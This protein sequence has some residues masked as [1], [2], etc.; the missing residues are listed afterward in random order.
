MSKCS[1]PVT[2]QLHNIYGSSF[3]KPLWYQL[4]IGWPIPRHPLSLLS[5]LSN[6]QKSVPRKVILN[7]A[8]VFENVTEII[9]TPFWSCKILWHDRMDLKYGKTMIFDRFKSVRIM[10][11][12]RWK[13]RKLKYH[14]FYN[15]VILLIWCEDFD[16]FEY[17]FIWFNR[18]AHTFDCSLDHV[19]SL[20]WSRDP[21]DMSP[22]TKK[23]LES[24]YE[25]KNKWLLQNLLIKH[26]G[27]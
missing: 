11:H 4:S 9:V 16:R 5:L 13:I 27:M 21:R 23:W 6:R 26:I 24:N 3:P 1:S 15:V 25:R 17:Y 22:V 18:R 19:T 7:K 14:V 12:N 20:E 10:I 8:L 2:L